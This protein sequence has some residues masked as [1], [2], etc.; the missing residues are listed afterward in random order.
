MLH[1]N[2]DIE[3]DE[4]YSPDEE[5][6]IEKRSEYWCAEC[7]IET[8]EKECPV[9]GKETV[10]GVPLQVYWCKNCNTPIIHKMNQ[11]DKGICPICGKKTKYLT[12]DIRPVFP[13]ER[14]L[15]ELL[16]DKEPHAFIRNSVWAADSRYYIDGKSIAIPNEL[17]QTADADARRKKLNEHQETNSS[18]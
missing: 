18:K 2:Y 17:F 16:L 4:T 12:T 9:C 5:E 3:I 15:L 8:S 13:E 10:E 11:I 7:K 6:F 1:E 14:L